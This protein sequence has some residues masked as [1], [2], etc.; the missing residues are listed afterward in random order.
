MVIEGVKEPR[1]VRDLVNR[2]AATARD[3]YLRKHQ[4]SFTEF[5]G[6]VAPAMA[7]T[8]APESVDPIAKLKEFKELLDAGILTE[9]EFAAEKAKLLG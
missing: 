4:Q 5:S 7:S 3:S 1:E 6:N 9:E 2:L 8:P